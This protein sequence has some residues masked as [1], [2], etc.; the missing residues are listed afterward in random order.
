MGQENR[1]K[2]MLASN[3]LD[4]QAGNC[5]L[6]KSKYVENVQAVLVS[7]AMKT[8]PSYFTLGDN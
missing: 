4:L 8:S 7:T 2:N 6:I 5:I 3:D 1:D